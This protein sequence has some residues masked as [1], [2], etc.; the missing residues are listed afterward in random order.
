MGSLPSYS[1]LNA[2]EAD[3]VGDQQFSDQNPTYLIALCRNEPPL[4]SLLDFLASAIAEDL[5]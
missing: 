3:L 5:P 2:W 4:T 1:S